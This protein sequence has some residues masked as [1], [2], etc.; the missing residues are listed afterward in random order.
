MEIHEMKTEASVIGLGAMG[1]ALARALLRSGYR[2]TVWNRTSSKAEPLVREGA[3]A[4][5]NVASAVGASRTVVVC[6]DNYQ[7]TKAILDTKEVAAALAGRVV[8]QLTT[9]SP[10]E[11]R[12]SEVWAREQGADYLD[13]KIFAWPR[14]IGTAEAAIF[15]S[16]AESAFRSSEPLLRSLAGMLLT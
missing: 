5:A 15:V 4:A 11:A 9:G 10:Q 6:V 2:V 16:G 8:V 12:D 13:G 1:S 3:I 7:V 14:H